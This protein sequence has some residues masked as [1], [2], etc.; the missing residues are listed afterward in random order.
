MVHVLPPIFMCKRI[1]VKLLDIHI[2]NLFSYLKTSERNQVKGI[3]SL[4][5]AHMSPLASVVLLLSTTLGIVCP[6]FIWDMVSIMCLFLS[7]KKV[8]MLE[9]EIGHGD[10][11]YSAG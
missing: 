10:D 1:V 8:L 11:I 9:S 6:V 2:N 5:L 7:V 4:P 3:I